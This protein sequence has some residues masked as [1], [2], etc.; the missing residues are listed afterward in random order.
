MNFLSDISSVQYRNAGIGRGYIQFTLMGGMEAKK[1]LS[2][3]ATDENTVL[4]GVSKQDMFDELRSRIND[5][6]NMILVTRM[7]ITAPATNWL[8][9]NSL[10]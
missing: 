5:I 9:S 7:N 6:A 10:D 3:A 8:I 4:F 2:Q 1:G